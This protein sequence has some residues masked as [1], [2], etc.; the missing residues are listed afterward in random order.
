M[1]KKRL[2]AIGLALAL[3]ALVACGV[4]PAPNTG[5]TEATAPPPLPARDGAVMPPPQGGP[6]LYAFRAAEPFE[7]R[8]NGHDTGPHPVFHYGLVNDMAEVVAPPRYEIVEYIHD[9]YGRITGLLAFAGRAVTRYTLDGTANPLPFT[10]TGVQPLLDGRHWIAFGV[11]E[12]DELGPRT[13]DVLTQNGVFDTETETF[14]IPPTDGLDIW[15][16]DG[17]VIANQYEA[18]DFGSPLVRSFLW[19]PEDGSERAFPEGWRCQGFFPETGWFEMVAFSDEGGF[20]IFIV[21][22]NMN[23]VPYLRTEWHIDESFGGGNFIV[24]R[25]MYNDFETT[26]VDRNGEF[27][28]LRFDMIQRWNRC[29]IAWSDGHRWDGGTPT[30]LDGQLNVLH[31]AQEGE[32]FIALFDAIDRQHDD[33]PKMIVLQDESGTVLNVWDA[34][35]G[36][37]FEGQSGR[38]LGGDGV[39]VLEDGEWLVINSAQ[40]REGDED[41][42]W[43][44]LVTEQGMI[45]QLAQEGETA[46]LSMRHI[47]IDWQGNPTEHPLQP[48]FEDGSLALRLDN[49]AAPFF[50]IEGE[51]QR[52][53]VDK[54]GEWL[55]I[56][57]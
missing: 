57:E 28:D 54:Y 13:H 15:A 24:V 40:F 22:D 44:V 16:R 43:I 25:N 19:N 33:I 56:D 23:V 27:S 20:E 38:W 55:F 7:Y 21:D 51:T 50:W 35:T 10:A 2:L 5:P 11:G 31:E 9:A 52:G 32:E 6:M 18:N 4:P 49:P 30:L 26:W 12:A 47:A 14:V 29:Y 41:A 3:L 42:S 34:Q 37:E 45:I 17:V 36:L 1:M 53:F 46:W 39:Y 8:E 48:F